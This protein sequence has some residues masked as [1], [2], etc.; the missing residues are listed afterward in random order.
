[1]LRDEA[2]RG[3]DKASAA[4]VDVELELWPDVPH[5]FQ[6][7]GFLPEA[8]LAIHHIVRF[9]RMRTGWSAASD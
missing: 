3:A 5:A 7:A 1:M 2:V 8:T 4:G 6:M 9:V